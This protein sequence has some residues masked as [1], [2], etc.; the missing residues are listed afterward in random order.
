V[1]TAEQAYEQTLDHVF[2]PNNP[3]SD[4]SQHSLYKRR[5]LL[6]CLL[7]RHAFVLPR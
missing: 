7:R 3:L 1:T 2:L 4:L 6:R 5:I